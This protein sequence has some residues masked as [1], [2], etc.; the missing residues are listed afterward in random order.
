[1]KHISILKGNGGITTVP[2]GWK[3]VEGATATM[4]GQEVWTQIKRGQV[5]NLSLPFGSDLSRSLHNGICNLTRLY[6]TKT[7]RQKH[8]S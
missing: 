4:S 2:L 7:L 1:M 3:S 5:G 6:L 8:L